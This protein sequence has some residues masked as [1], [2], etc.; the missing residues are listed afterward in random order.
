MTMHYFTETGFTQ[1]QIKYNQLI[2]NSFFFDNS[3][4]KYELTDIINPNYAIGKC[5]ISQVTTF[6]F[7]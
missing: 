4:A 7:S 1:V 2:G 3:E 5:A 6:G